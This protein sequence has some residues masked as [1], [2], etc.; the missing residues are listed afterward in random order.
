MKRILVMFLAALGL[1]AVACAGA[2]AADLLE[3]Q[4]L[5][6]SAGKSARR[7]G[8][9]DLFF[10]SLEPGFR[11]G[12][13]TA[14]VGIN[15]YFDDDF[16]VRD[17]GNDLIMLSSLTYEDPDRMRIYYGEIE[18]LTLG[19]GFVVS[20]YRSNI[21][22]N[23][24]MTNM[25]GLEFDLW[26][27]RS[28][29]KVFGTRTH[30][31]GL[32]AVRNMGRFDIGTT[33]VTDAEPDFEEIAIDLQATVFPEKFSVYTEVATIQDYGDG[34]ALGALGTPFRFMDIKA[35]IRDFDS[36]FVPGIVDEHYEARPVVDRIKANKTGRLWGFYSAV[37]FFRGRRISATLTYEDYE[38]YKSRYTI[39]GRAKLT[40][41]IYGDLFFAKENFVLQTGGYS[42][43]S[44]ASARLNIKATKRLDL[45]FDFYNAY[46]DHRDTLEA[47]T[48]K[49]R[50]HLW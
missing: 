7:V 33:A 21:R 50:Y 35:E 13:L 4:A 23:V 1:I 31:L 39:T 34:F 37:D 30:L 40:D 6:W 38:D 41:R 46:D 19:S 12:N 8:G 45:I 28:A 10:V 14:F 18:N 43:D 5:S 32:R 16:K 20:N 9:P 42:E 15:Y 24:P 49:T 44:I 36:D 48:V 22:N 11:V 3:P 29:I 2:R 27:P 47:L 17:G 26:G 25:Q